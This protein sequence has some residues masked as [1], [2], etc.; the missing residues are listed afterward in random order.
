M[1]PEVLPQRPLNLL[2]DLVR[3]AP[4]ETSTREHIDATLNYLEA[5]M[6]SWTAEQDRRLQ[7]AEKRIKL[8]A[9]LHGMALGMGAPSDYRIHGK[10]FSWCPFE[11]WMGNEYAGLAE[12]LNYRP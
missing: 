12:M 3:L 11:E 2:A 7:K 8:C 4:P 9:M 6:D 10:H 1:N 5:R